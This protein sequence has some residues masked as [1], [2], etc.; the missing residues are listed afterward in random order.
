MPFIRPKELASDNGPEW[1]SWQHLVKHLNQ[2]NK[3]P[4]AL[5]SVPTSS[6][7]RNHNDIEKCIDKYITG[8]FD[9]IIELQ[10]KEKSIF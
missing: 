1:N 9:C 10:I 7:L 8:S 6:P 2:L 3:L 5:V 4:D